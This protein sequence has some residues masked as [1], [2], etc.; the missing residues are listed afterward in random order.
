MSK[1]RGGASAP[2]ISG[3]SRGGAGAQI[4]GPAGARGPLGGVVRPGRRRPRGALGFAS[5]AL[6]LAVAPLALSQ[7]GGQ[8]APAASAVPAAAPTTS[9][10]SATAAPT[11]AAPGATAAPTTAAPS[12]TAAPTTAAPGVTA[13]AAPAVQPFAPPM[14]VGRK[15]APPPPPPTPAQ[16][17]ALAALEKEAS[18]YEKAAR[19]YRSA[20]TRIVQHHYEDRR[21]RILS[22]LDREIEIERK[23][24]RDAREEAIRR[25]EVF[26]ERYSGPNAHPENTPDAMF[27]LA[28]LYEERARTD[29]DA[30]EDLSVALLPA[31][32]LYKRVI[33]EFP[34]YRELAGIYY[35][36]GHALNDSVRFPEAQQVWRSLVCH[37]KYPYPV[38]T[39]PKDPTRDIV[40]KLP[41][42]HDN[43][44]WTGWEARHPTP[45]GSTP[46]GRALQA[47]KGARGRAPVTEDETA[48]VDP[49]T[50]DCQPIPQ[51]TALGAE[52]RYVAEVWW[53]IGDYHF[54]EID[55]AGGPFNYNRAESAYRQSIKYKKPPVHGVAM[56]KLAWTYFKQQRYET[57]VRQFIEL[58]RYTDEQEKLTGDPGADF[59]AEAYTYIAGSLTY[60][61]FV[62][63]GPDEPYVPRN[64]VLDVETDPRMAEQKMRIAID[65]VQDPKLIPQDQKWTVEIYKALALEF[66]ELNQYRNTI[67]V[68][69][70]LLKKWPMHRDAPVVQNQIA[71]I[72]DTLTSQS[73]E[74]TAERAMNSAKAL[75][76]RTKLAQYV[77]TTPWVEAN[78]DDPEAIQTA[79]RLVRGG[80]RRAAA[81]HTNA[82][83]A[84]VQ[85]ALTV[86]DKETRDP[87]FERALGEY[88]LA[89]QGWAGYLAQDENAPDAY[90]SRYWLADAHHMVV[91]ITVA[92]DRSPATHEIEQARSSAVGVRDS[93]EDDKY[94]QPAA[95][96]VV[97]TAH[98]ALLDRHKLFQRTSG[99]EGIEPREKVKIVGEGDQQRVVAE[100]LPPQVQAAVTARDEYIQRV[101]PALDAPKNLDLYAF[102]A[103]DYY[104]L[105]GQFAEARKRMEP[106]YEAQCGKTEFGYKAWERL[107]TMSNLENN[108]EQS[109]KLAEAALT[110][111]CAVSEEQKLKEGDIARP[112]ISRGYYIDAARA[113]EKAEK[114]PDG[115][116][117]VA[118]WR[119]AA[120][121]YKVALEKA[122]A[123]DEAPEAAMNGAYCYKQV[124]DYDQAIEM[125]SLFIKEYGSEENLSKLEKGDPGAN[126]PK[127]PDPKRYAERVK[128]LKQAY[129]A[130]S[131]AY[132]LFFNYRSAAETYDTIARNG[133]FEQAA[134]RDAARNSVL[135]Y[136]NIGERDKMT[137]SRATFM[138]LNPPPEQKADIDFLVASA[139]LKAWDERGAD[140]GPNR[141]AR[142]KATQ[143]ME[144]YYAANKNNPA[145]S[146]YVVQAA[147]HASKMRAAGGDPKA[148]DWCKNTM[149]AFTSF[150]N[151]ATGDKVK[152]LGSVQADMAAECAYKAI[153]D[154]IK[155]EFDYD[156]GHHRYEGVIDQV[157][158]AFEADITKA[159]DRYWKE[160][161]EVITAYESR[162][163]SVAAR[164]RQGSLYDSCRTGLY[165]ARPPGLRLY[166]D[167]EE[168]L[169]KLAETSDRED[170]QETADAL[171]QNRREQWRAARERLLNDADKAMVK[172][173][174]ESV[175]WAKAWKVRNPAVDLAIQRLAFFTDILGDAKLRE[176]SQ[177]VI[178]PETKRPFEYKDGLFLRTR[179]GMTPPLAPDGLPLPLPV[180]P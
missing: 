1:E 76:A 52:P 38:E 88:R 107:T 18:A 157:K 5:L 123:R 27:R 140:E 120:A 94:L 10:P 32:A 137:A 145:A 118:A 62:G 6:V 17:A 81:D 104:F 159:N 8:P 34:Q 111:S 92:M 54:N 2:Q 59:R 9:A 161:Q 43:D 67:E 174:V 141:A 172:F 176:W 149:T 164:A 84:L 132:V 37:N 112:T 151:S 72:Y 116:A 170:L 179:P 58:L 80:L 103:A 22:S 101:P 142:T 169:L 85:Q 61:D 113:F 51:K 115:P 127:N 119:E 87:I 79:E 156:T 3:A 124:G 177:G 7:P 13:P 65:R 21:R 152:A 158:R 86:G 49:Y 14:S 131:A 175:V 99:A 108:V 117:R 125:Y 126:P 50:D 29:N 97:D 165:N 168:K 171:R 139:D 121:L 20:I 24:L 12:A 66:K 33:R 36:L 11:T 100:P 35:Y 160:L 106:I 45:I 178:D 75:E 102:Q 68:S 163:W 173:Y 162:P 129:D 110:R 44:Y 39:D 166:T 180:V 71:D 146:G 154:R 55:R 153:D 42:D 150:R 148:R 143:S 57:S 134:R 133:R 28:A 47:R 77:G 135:L 130:L 109:R 46:G 89:A 128:Y 63:P 98:Q 83:S 26:V 96:M 53:Q 122:P 56:Y 19:D 15:Q 91:V 69:E 138:S 73:R 30:S 167:K 147:Y 70:I 93:N 40:G 74:G 155:A 60:L 4:L 48:Y 16:L 25:L 114:M 90:E 64:D 136:A 82:G 31:I 78:K 105:Y 23:G 95:Y 41:Q 144:A